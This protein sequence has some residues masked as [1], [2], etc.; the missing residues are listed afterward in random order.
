MTLAEPPALAPLGLP[1]ERE[2]WEGVA[3]LPP[4][5]AGKVGE[6]YIE[7][8]PRAGQTRLL[9]ARC[10]VPF[11]V[12]RALYPERNW[13]ELAHLLVTMPT[14]GFVQGDAVSMQVLAQPGTQVHLTSQSATR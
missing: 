10:R 2:Q 4:G 6:L 3:T 9:D 5:S 1:R 13:P 14:G 11:H 8:G 12:G 7:L